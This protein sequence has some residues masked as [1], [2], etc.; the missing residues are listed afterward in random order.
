MENQIKLNN[1]LVLT[2]VLLGAVFFFIFIM[3]TI[4]SK[5]K[6][7]LN[8]LKE[9]FD[10]KPNNEIRKLDRNICS[11]QCCNHSQW[12]VPHDAKTGPIPK[13][14]LNNYIGT[15]LS[16]NFGDGSGCL[17]VTKDDFNYLANRGGNSGNNMCK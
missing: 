3:P 5:Q 4:E 17:C 8:K 7:D 14:K 6:K 12:P 9:G 10:N 15:N 13:D 16:C 2:M 1:N 11:K